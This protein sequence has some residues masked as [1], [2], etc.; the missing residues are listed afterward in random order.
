MVML[1]MS[2]N[3]DHDR[4]AIICLVTDRSCS[5]TASFS[6]CPAR[7]GHAEGLDHPDA[8]CRL[9][10]DAGDLT[11]LVLDPARRDDEVAREV[12]GH[13]E[14]WDRRSRHHHAQPQVFGDQLH[15]YGYVD[16]Y[17]HEPEDETQA[18]NLRMD[19]QIGGN[20]GKQLSRLPA[21]VESCMKLLHVGV[22]VR[23]NIGLHAQR[24][25]GLDVTAKPHEN[26]FADTEKG[27][28]HAQPPQAAEVAVGDGA[29]DD[30]LDQSGD[31]KLGGG[32]RARQQQHGEHPEPV[33]AKV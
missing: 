4:E 6:N 19:P 8:L 2:E 11:L 17:A 24:D 14:Q 3:S 20:T 29:V 12:P 26:T 25:T 18:M 31:Q 10:G 13:D 27:N 28:D 22:E 15:R 1:G 32:R 9:F 30:G 7:G 5:A 16:R 23:P 33:R 21:V